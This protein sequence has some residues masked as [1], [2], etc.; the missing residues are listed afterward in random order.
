MREG[1]SIDEIGKMQEQPGEKRDGGVSW[2][3][4]VGGMEF[5]CSPAVLLLHAL[6][7]ITCDSPWLAKQPW[8]SGGHV[9][10]ATLWSVG[11]LLKL[12][13]IENN[14]HSVRYLQ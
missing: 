2:L 8:M 10:K 7:Q 6:A 12:S 11:R 9:A 14:A 3:L 1:I 5:E 4:I 13:L